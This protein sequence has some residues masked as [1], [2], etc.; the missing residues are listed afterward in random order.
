LEGVFD[1]PYSSQEAMDM[2]SI[3]GTHEA[4]NFSISSEVASLD[5][6]LYR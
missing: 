3:V 6:L 5:D 2:G 4:S 1:I